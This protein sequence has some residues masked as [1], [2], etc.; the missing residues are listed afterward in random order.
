MWTANHWV[1]LLTGRLGGRIGWDPRQRPK[2]V[3][4]GNIEDRTCPRFRHAP[5]KDLAGQQCP[6]QVQVKDPLDRISREVKEWQLRGS[7][8]LAFI[9]SRAVDEKINHSVGLDDLLGGGFDSRLV[10]DVTL[11]RQGLPTSITDHFSHPFGSLQRQIQDRDLGSSLGQS[12]AH[13]AAQDTATA[14]D[15]RDF[16][17]QAK[18][19][20]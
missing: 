14:G 19:T 20:R 3:H 2:G 10:Q 8:R 17:C 5:T 18:E 16:A 7:S 15:N 9:T 4:G 1:K 13:S 12:S 11:K 6:D